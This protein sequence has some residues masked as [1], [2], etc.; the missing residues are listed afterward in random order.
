MH[1]E[2]WWRNLQAMC[3]FSHFHLISLDVR[4]FFYIL[5]SLKIKSI[6]KEPQWTQ[7]YCQPGSICANLI[8]THYNSTLSKWARNWVHFLHWK[9]VTW[10][11]EEG[12]VGRPLDKITSFSMYHRPV[13]LMGSR[14]GHGWIKWYLRSKVLL[15]H[16]MKACRVSWGTAPL[17]VD[18]DTRWEK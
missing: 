4:F 8:R 14:S 12:V 1:T 18:L 7:K 3:L 5:K 16:A 6:P 2:F 15:I 11:L 17:I 13:V 9:A 10:K